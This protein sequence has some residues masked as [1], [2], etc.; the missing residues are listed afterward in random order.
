M[1]DGTKMHDALI[2]MVHVHAYTSINPAVWKKCVCMS[3]IENYPCGCSDSLLLLFVVSFSS[4]WTIS[5]RFETEDPKSLRLT[6]SNW[7]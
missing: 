6:D 5:T 4:A 7:I 2:R 3:S 1:M